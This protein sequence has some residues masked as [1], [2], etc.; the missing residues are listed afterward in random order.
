[1]EITDYHNVSNYFK[2]LNFY[3]SNFLGTNAA[4]MYAEYPQQHRSN[5]RGNK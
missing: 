4:R 3:W 1:M 2:V 5:Y